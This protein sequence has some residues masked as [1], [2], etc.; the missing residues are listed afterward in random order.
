VT[1]VEYGDFECPHC[2]RAHFSL[3]ELLP[4]MGKQMRLVF[5]HFPLRQIHPHAA[6]AA[7][8]AEAAGAQG[9]FWDMHDIL[10]ERQ[11]ALEDNDLVS[12][13]A[14]IGLDAQRFQLELLQHVH[15][16]RVRED[17]LSGVRSGV[18]GTPT[19]FINGRRHDG[20]WDL[21]ALSTA[22]VQAMTWHESSGSAAHDG[23]GHR[24][25]HHR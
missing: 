4:K 6:H 17:F 18:N 24:R 19:F 15:A 16:P 12:Y 5:R 14:E 25:S 7:E 13:A 9:R 20:P 21:E 10:F 8:A 22:I 1:L 2:G 23:A 3:Q 11:D